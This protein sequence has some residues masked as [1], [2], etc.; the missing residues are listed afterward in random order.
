MVTVSCLLILS[1]ASSLLQN[2]RLCRKPHNSSSPAVNH[3]S[4]AGADGSSED[5][6]ETARLSLTPQLVLVCPHFSSGSPEENNKMFLLPAV[7]LCCVSSALAAMT[8]E[9]KQDSLSLTRRVGENVSFRCERLDQCDYNDYVFWYQKKDNETFTRILWI[10]KSNG[11]VNK[12][13]YNHPQ[14]DDFSAVIK[15][16]GVE[17]QIQKVNS[18]HSAT[19]YC[20]CWK[21]VNPHRGLILVHDLCSSPADRFL[22]H[23]FSLWGDYLIFGSGTR[24]FVSDEEQVV[25]PVVSV[26]PA[27]S[28]GRLEEKSSLLCVASAMFPPVVRISWTRQ[29]ESGCLEE[30]PSADGQQLELRES[31]C[32]ASVLQ[33]YQTKFSYEYSCYVQ[34]EGGTVEARIDTGNEA[35]PSVPSPYKVKLLLLLYTVLTVKSLVYCCGLFLLTVLRNIS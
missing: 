32:T 28:R 17:L 7:A 8:T 5:L 27:A 29:T 34:H 14:K 21:S 3:Q 1:S 31:G 24:L 35:D 6:L 26:Y 15:Q 9:L 16:N 4:A 10:D 11:K 13:S 25:K 23:V 20:S 18:S 33:I 2:L 30:L 12:D 22:Y 19:Y